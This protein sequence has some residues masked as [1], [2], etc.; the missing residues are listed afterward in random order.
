M[1]SA[2][3]G[4]TG[5][6]DPLEQ[7]HSVLQR[8]E[9]LVKPQLDQLRQAIDHTLSELRRLEEQHLD[10]QRRALAELRARLRLDARFVL[11]AAAFRG[12]LGRLEDERLP[13][14]FRVTFPADPARWVL[15]TLPLPLQLRGGERRQQQDYEEEHDCLRDLLAVRIHLG[16]LSV[17][18]EVEQRARL[19]G[20][21][22]EVPLAYQHQELSFALGEHLEKLDLGEA[23]SRTLSR[24]VAAVVLYAAPMLLEEPSGVTFSYP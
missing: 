5:T 17:S 6:R 15:D 14:A 8:H 13:P 18:A 7:Y 19:L 21:V 2:R 9:A 11:H 23:L 16:P 4:G 12:F 1:W 10:Q 24:E 22:R 20:E 3:I